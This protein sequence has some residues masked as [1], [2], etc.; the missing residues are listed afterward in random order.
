[1]MGVFGHGNDQDVV[2]LQRN[3]VLVIFATIYFVW[4]IISGL[5]YLRL[6]I[7][8]KNTKNEACTRSTE[9]FPF[10][11]ALKLKRESPTFGIFI[12]TLS[13]LLIWV[14][15][16]QIIITMV[17]MSQPPSSNPEAYVTASPKILMVLG[18]VTTF[19]QEVPLQ[20]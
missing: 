7:I 5:W 15:G 11:Y 19:V 1:M 6:S 14:A 12:Y 13:K 4:R 9:T 8:T 16:L 2:L 18:L 17:F 3:L 20:G 10:S